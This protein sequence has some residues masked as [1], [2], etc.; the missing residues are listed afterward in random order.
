MILNEG[1]VEGLVSRA[2][3]CQVMPDKSDEAAVR[4]LSGMQ[5]TA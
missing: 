5:W 4:Y 1:R 2:W 3:I